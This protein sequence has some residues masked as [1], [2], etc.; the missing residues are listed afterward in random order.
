MADQVTIEIDTV[1]S[2][3]GVLLDELEKSFGPSV[4]VPVDGY[5]HL[6]VKAAFDMSRGVGEL[7][8][9]R[10]ADDVDEVREIVTDPASAATPT[11]HGLAHII[12][13]LRALELIAL[14]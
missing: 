9:G 6:P 5:W 4:R 11:W 10:L 8:V 2:A 13:V 3:L 14:P 7:T 12:G 1:R